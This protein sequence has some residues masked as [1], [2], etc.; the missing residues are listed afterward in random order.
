MTDQ[1]PMESFFPIF[2][3]VWSGK[4]VC[5]LIQNSNTIQEIKVILQDRELVTMEDVV[6]NFEGKILIDTYP[7]SKYTIGRNLTLNMTIRLRGGVVGKGASSSSKPS[8][9]EAVWK[10]S[11]PIQHAK[12][13]PKEYI[14]EQAEQSSC[15]EL[16]DPT[17]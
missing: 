15:V 4:I 9:Q 7:I 14:V 17:I 6:L 10:K 8:F 16:Q 11:S 12:T 13:K 5:M 2:I 1:S 3:R